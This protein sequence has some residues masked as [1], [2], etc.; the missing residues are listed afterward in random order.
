MLARLKVRTHGRMLWLRTITSTILGE[1]I[2][3]ALFISIA[4]AGIFSGADLRTAIL[5]QWLIKVAFETLAT[6]FTYLLVNTLKKAEGI[7]FYDED[8]NFSP[9]AM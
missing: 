9:L 6:P 5:S 4:F 2:D 8:T 7:D 1:G 3:S